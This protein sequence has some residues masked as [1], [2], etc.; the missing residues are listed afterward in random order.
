MKPTVT[1]LPI[2]FKPTHSQKIIIRPHRRKLAGWW[3][4]QGTKKP[5]IICFVCFVYFV[6]SVTASTI[7]GNIQNTSGNAYVTNALFAPLS[8]PL[9]SGTNIIASTPTNVVAGAN[10]SF[11]VTLKQGN[12]L[13]TLGNLRHDSFTISVP[14]DSNTYIVNSLITS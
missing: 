13:V 10:G 6:V 4:R 12:Y 2:T 7:T 1:K 11:S 9:V 14:D 5:S 8:T 3:L